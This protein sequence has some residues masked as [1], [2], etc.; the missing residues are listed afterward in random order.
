MDIYDKTLLGLSY[1]THLRSQIEME[2]IHPVYPYGMDNY[3]FCLN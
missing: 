2:N 1:H 3:A